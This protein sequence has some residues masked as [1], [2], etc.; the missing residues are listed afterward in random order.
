MEWRRALTVG[1][2]VGLA[3]LLI[4][5]TNEPWQTGLTAAAGVV[6]VLFLWNW[7]NGGG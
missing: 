2:I 1:A 5:A 7:R 6:I 3:A 4:E